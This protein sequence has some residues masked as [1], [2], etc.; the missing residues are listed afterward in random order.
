MYWGCG[1]LR[2]ILLRFQKKLFGEAVIGKHG[3]A[4]VFKG[5]FGKSACFVMVFLW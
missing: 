3:V 2:K 5:G 1:I 4:G